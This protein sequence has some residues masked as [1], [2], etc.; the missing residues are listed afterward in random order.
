MNKLVLQVV[1]L[2]TGEVVKE[3][4]P[5]STTDRYL[6]KLE[7]GLIRNMNTEKYCVK[8]ATVKE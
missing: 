4:V 6:E 1:D 8:R 2:E 3:I 7:L 5:Q